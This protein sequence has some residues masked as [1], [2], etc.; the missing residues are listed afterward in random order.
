[1]C[2]QVFQGNINYLQEV[3][4]NFIP[5]IEARYVRIN[6]SLWHQRIAIK[7]ELLGCQTFT[8]PRFTP[9]AAGTK[10]PPRLGQTTHTP[11]I[12]NT[13]MPPHTSKGSVRPKRVGVCRLL[14]HV[15]L[16]SQMWRWLPSWCPCQ[17][18][19]SPLSLWSW[20]AP[21]TGGTGTWACDG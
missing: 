17:S 10:R 3:R 8:S 6:P 1:M 21:G 7:M 18:W 13:T 9:R 5:P 12:R 19:S 11:D 2:R 14:S 20:R 4:N 16:C 15:C